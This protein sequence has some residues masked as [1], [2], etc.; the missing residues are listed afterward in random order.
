MNQVDIEITKVK[1]ITRMQTSFPLDKGLY[2]LVGENHSLQ[3]FDGDSAAASRG[4]GSG[5]EGFSGRFGRKLYTKFGAQFQWLCTS[6]QRLRPFSIPWSGRWAKSFGRWSRRGRR[7][8]GENQLE[9][10]TKIEKN[11]IQIAH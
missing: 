3:G 4:C 7:N 1:N 11:T 6:R 10:C 5:Y 2:A 9:D 8:R